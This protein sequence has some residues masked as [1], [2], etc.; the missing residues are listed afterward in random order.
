[1]I[2]LEKIKCEDSL[3]GN[4]IIRYSDN[5]VETVDKVTGYRGNQ[6]L[7]TFVMYRFSVVKERCS[8]D[9]KVD[10]DIG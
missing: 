4:G 8:V 9:S 6:I 5:S 3:V 1:M 7:D 10:L 2:L